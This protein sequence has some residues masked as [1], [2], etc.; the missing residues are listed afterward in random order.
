MP[1]DPA[2]TTPGLA[3][4]AAP[5]EQ[6]NMRCRSGGR[7][8]SMTAV[9]MKIPGQE[10]LRMYRCTGCNHTWGLNVGGSVNL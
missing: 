6:I 10:S 9:I 7:C 4:G 5:E 3:P 1:V 2:G 8:D